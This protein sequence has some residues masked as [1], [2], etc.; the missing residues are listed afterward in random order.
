MRLSPHARKAALAAHLSFSIGWIG[1]VLAFLALVLAAMAR[2]DAAVLRA[3]WVGMELTGWL[4]IA[5][6][7]V[8]SLLTGLLMSLGTKWGL[9]R[10]YWTLVSLVLTL[11]A[12]AV[13]MGNL[14][15]VSAYAR[16]AAE[17]SPDLVHLRGGL[18]GELL[19]AGAGLVVLLVVQVINIYKPAGLTKHGRRAQA[20]ARP[21]EP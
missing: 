11:L 9:F 7:A 12:V 1:A 19:H 10:H 2:E 3:A 4:V 17:E 18:G 16:V 13:L 21:V 14:Q 8:A 5:P 6:L 20:A 15:T